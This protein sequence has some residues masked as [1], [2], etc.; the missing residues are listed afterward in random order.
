MFRTAP[1][2]TADDRPRRIVKRVSG[3]LAL[4]CL[5]ALIYVAA[6]VATM[7]ANAL[8]DFVTIP[9]QVTALYGTIWH[10]RAELTG[11]YAV[12]WDN[13]PT[14]LIMLR[15]T[16]AATVQGADTQLRGTVRITPWSASVHNLTGR[17]GA[18]LLRLVPGLLIE[19]CTTQAVVD[20]TRLALARTWAAAE[21]Q[22][23]VGAGDCMETNGRT[24]P[25]PALALTLGTVGRD[26]TAVLKTGDVTLADVTV[27]GD[28]RLSVTVQPEGSALVPGLPTGAP[29]M[30]EYPF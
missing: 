27:S 16:V 30:I 1:K 26:A 11:G 15:G 29:I 12:D 23:D 20:V 8:R 5:T 24:N 13:I 9:P 3:Y 28:H 7:P 25:V 4:A 21:G 22:V 18:G 17:A 6:L 2:E 14:D 19:N 10:G